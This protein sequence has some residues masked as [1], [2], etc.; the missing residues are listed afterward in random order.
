MVKSLHEKLE[1]HAKCEKV[2]APGWRRSKR[3][4]SSVQAP[5][6]IL[7]NRWKKVGSIG[8]ER[9]KASD[10]PGQKM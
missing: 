7:L 3:Q 1:L 9:Q 8:V 10:F 6:G 5:N 2:I 4:S